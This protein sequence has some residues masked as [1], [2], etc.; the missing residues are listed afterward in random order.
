MPTAG[1]P[2]KWAEGVCLLHYLLSKEKKNPDSFY[3]R[4]DDVV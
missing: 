1:T 3:S 4:W 2:E